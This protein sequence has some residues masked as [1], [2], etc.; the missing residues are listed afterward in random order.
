MKAISNFPT[1]L[2]RFFPKI[3]V[4]S[5]YL[6]QENIWFAI[7]LN[8]YIKANLLFPDATLKE[9]NQ[10]SNFVIFDIFGISDDLKNKEEKK[11]LA[12][13]LRESLFSDENI[14]DILANYFLIEHFRFLTQ[15][16]DGHNKIYKEK[17]D[18][19]LSKAKS[20]KNT[21]EPISA[22]DVNNI[23]KE[24]KKEIK[25][26]KKLNK[27]INQTKIEKEKEKRIK[28]IKITPS[29]IFLF[30]SVFSSLFL[31]GGFLYIAIEYCYIF[32]VLI[33]AISLIFLII[34]RVVLT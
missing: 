10:L 16:E 1:F 12:E 14:I 9:N 34:L 31:V 5:L 24:I 22:K 15:Y 27:K 3:I 13:Q 4:R 23:N 17:A 18:E 26:L 33:V 30:I 29:A 21:A 2:Y 20:Y 19:A 25:I 11:E 7:I 28:R 8:A 32:L 6:S